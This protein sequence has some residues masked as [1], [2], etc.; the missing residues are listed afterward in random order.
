M[1]ECACSPTGN[2]RGGRPKL[3]APPSGPE[4]PP[5]S[6]NTHR[7]E[8]TDAS[9]YLLCSPTT[10]NDE[11]LH[12]FLQVVD[13]T[14]L[15]IHL[16]QERVLSK[17]HDALICKHTCRSIG[18][19]F[20][21]MSVISAR[22]FISSASIAFSFGLLC[23]A[24]QGKGGSTVQGVTVTHAHTHAHTHTRMMAVANTN[25]RNRQL[26][27]T[28]SSNSGGGVR[29]SCFILGK[30]TSRYCGHVSERK[31]FNGQPECTTH[32]CHAPSLAAPHRCS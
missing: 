23:S 21:V 31:R 26:R 32:A 2:P 30:R 11:L 27:R 7:Q 22:K 24:K 19:M 28:K 18:F 4:Q 6:M 25:H 29:F 14:T 9:A 20:T 15:A 8:Q 13:G 17:Q 5:H 1:L 10:V 12:W 3:P 16:Q